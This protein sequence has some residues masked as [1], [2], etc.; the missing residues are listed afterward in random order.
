MYCFY[1]LIVVPPLT[2]KMRE[3]MLRPNEQISL[4]LSPHLATVYMTL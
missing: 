2:W 4:S 1:D 3:W